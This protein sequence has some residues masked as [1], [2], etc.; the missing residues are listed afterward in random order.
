MIT[1]LK[2]K[3]I[4]ATSMDDVEIKIYASSSVKEKLLEYRYAYMTR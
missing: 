3:T 1:N 2:K 4:I